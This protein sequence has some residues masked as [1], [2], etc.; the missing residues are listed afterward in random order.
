MCSIRICRYGFLTGRLEL[1]YR[2]S[3]PTKIL[4]LA[5]IQLWAGFGKWLR[6]KDNYRSRLVTFKTWKNFN[7]M[8]VPRYKNAWHIIKKDIIASSVRD[9]KDV[10]KLKKNSQF[11][12]KWTSPDLPRQMIIFAE[13]E[14]AHANGLRIMSSVLVALGVTPE[15]WFGL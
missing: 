15:L 7:R 5:G 3:I 14:N 2:L 10:N 13:W 12:L 6:P 9:V 4:N 8:G 11:R 1:A